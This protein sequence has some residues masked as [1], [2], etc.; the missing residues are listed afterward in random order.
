MT[1]TSKEEEDKD[2]ELA[3]IGMSNEKNERE[4]EEAVLNL[5]SLKGNESSMFGKLMVGST[6]L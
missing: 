6:G 4:E 3:I 5:V 2:D 1:V